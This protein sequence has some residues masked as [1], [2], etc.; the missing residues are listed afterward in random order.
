MSLCATT[1]KDLLE[2]GLV[3][4][5]ACKE[6]IGLIDRSS[7][8]VIVTGPR[9]SGKTTTLLQYQEKKLNSGNDAIHITIDSTVLSSC[10]SDNLKKEQYELFLSLRILNYVKKYYGLIFEKKFR[11]LYDEINIKETLFYKGIDQ[12]Y[13]SDK[14]EKLNNY[15]G[16]LVKQI[17]DLFK[18][19]VGMDSLT[20]ILDRFDWVNDSEKFQNMAKFYLDIFDRYII[21]TDEK[22]VYTSNNRQLDLAERG[23]DIVGID[24]GKKIHQTKKIVSSEFEYIKKAKINLS[25][26]YIDPKKALSI[27]EYTELIRK[28]DGDFNLLYET[29][30]Y[31]NIRELRKEELMLAFNE[32]LNNKE[33]LEEM[34]PVKKLFI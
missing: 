24:Y 8:N 21:T 13:F 27:S 3:N 28:C 7:K 10:I 15:D 22:E 17:I 9:S 6:S 34:T 33:R 20:I 2:K 29:I 25:P 11:L 31:F 18:K 19:E 30:R 32:A 4:K 16:T 26:K 14:K 23:Y 1:P 12:S 5:T